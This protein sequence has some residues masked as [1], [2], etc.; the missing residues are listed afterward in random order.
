MDSVSGGTF[1]CDAYGIVS[2]GQNFLQMGTGPNAFKVLGIE[3][4]W[5]IGTVR[6]SFFRGNIKVTE[7]R[8]IFYRGRELNYRIEGT[9][10][11]WSFVKELAEGF[12]AE[13]ERNGTVFD[14]DNDD[15]IVTG[16][17]R[18]IFG[19]GGIFNNSG[20]VYGGSLV[21]IAGDLTVSRTRSSP[22]S[23]D[24]FF[25]RKRN[26]SGGNRHHPYERDFGKDEKAEKDDDQCCVCLDNRKTCAVFPCG[27]VCL[28]GACAKDEKKLEG[29]CPMCRKP[30]EDVRR[31]YS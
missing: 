1:V 4:G 30:L 5:T 3:T 23:S 31:T 28:C 20:N 18:R 17:G 11:E 8:R 6:G 2:G 25:S 12:R 29:K 22:R 15:T 9:E 27:H 26:T 24:V 13:A 19:P 21:Q 7:D 16:S 14:D 10:I